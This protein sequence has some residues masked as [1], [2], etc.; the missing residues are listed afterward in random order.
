[1]VL[2]AARIRCLQIQL[3]QEIWKKDDLQTT[4]IWGLTVRA[5]SKTT[6]SFR[7]DGVGSMLALQN[8]G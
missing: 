6:P 3:M 4:E 5:L 2:V 1:M 7:A 8:V